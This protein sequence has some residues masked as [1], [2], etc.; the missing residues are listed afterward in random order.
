MPTFGC[1]RSSTLTRYCSCLILIFK[2]RHHPPTIY[3]T[4]K[5]NRQRRV[6][7]ETT[8]KQPEQIVCGRPASTPSPGRTDEG[9][10]RTG[11]PDDYQRV[12]GRPTR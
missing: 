6:G 9:H 7:A 4:M 5:G 11:T 1:T 10:R 3:R 12:D 8:E 2:F